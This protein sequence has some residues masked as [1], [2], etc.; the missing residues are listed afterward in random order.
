MMQTD[1]ERLTARVRDAVRQASLR[2]RPYFVGFLDPSQAALCAREAGAGASALAWG[3]FCGAE[4]VVFGVF[5]PEQSPDPARFPVSALEVRFRRGAGLTHRDFLG[6]LMALGVE[7]DTVG[8]LLIEDGRAVLFVR[9]ELAAHLAQQLDRVG[10][11]GVHTVEAADPVLPPPP[12]LEPI[13]TTV[14]SARLDC[15]VAALAHCGRTE[16]ASR[17]ARGLVSC[18]GEVRTES[19][20]AV[21][22]GD[23]IAI[24]GEGKFRIDAL[25]PRTKKQRLSLRAG[26]Y[27]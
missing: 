27:A 22:E 9:R 14:A 10:R 25:G 3:G 5:P 17:I 23:V 11:E 8:D 7:R 26:K 2:G 15:V 6:S 24:R 12:T 19:D 21:T 20:A 18:S 13:S 1:A 16:A 4:R